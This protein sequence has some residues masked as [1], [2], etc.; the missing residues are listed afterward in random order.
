MTRVNGNGNG[1][2]PEEIKARREAFNKI[3]EEGHT[4]ELTVQKKD[5]KNSGVSYDY[6]DRLNKDIEAG[7]FVDNN[8]DGKNNQFSNYDKRNLGNEFTDVFTEHGYST[9]F[10]KMKAGEKYEITFDDYVRLA[11]AAGYELVKEEKPAPAPVEK[12]MPEIKPVPFT[13]PETKIPELKI[14]P[15]EPQAEQNDTVTWDI[16][17]TEYPDGSK[18]RVGSYS[19]NGEETP[20]SEFVEA[21]EQTGKKVV[22]EPD[23][24][25]A[26]AS[27]DKGIP[28]VEEVAVSEVKEEAP[29][30]PAHRPFLTAPVKAA[31][32]TIP[33]V[34]ADLDKPIKKLDIAP[35][36]VTETETAPKAKEEAPAAAPAEVETA[37]EEAPATQETQ[38]AEEKLTAAIDSD[39]LLAGKTTEERLNALRNWGFEATKKERELKRTTV[40]ETKPRF[41]GL[42][43][44]EYERALTPEELA[45]NQ[46]ALQELAAEKD[47]YKK[48]EVYVKNVENDE[49]WNGLYASQDLRDKNGN[50]VAEYPQYDRVTVVDAQDNERRVARVNT[51]NPKTLETTTQYFSL[52]VQKV[53]DPTMGSGV[54]Y[55]VVPDTTN[56]LKDVQLKKYEYTHSR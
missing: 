3:K 10:G 5:P 14:K 46:Q 23:A 2:T 9:K 18:E 54:Y 47:K 53:G 38:T 36:Q 34:T 11:D 33:T 30:A 13:I 51:Y 12:K 21:P 16:T 37:K 20:V 27:N 8:K 48:Y 29:A 44:K 4:I 56:E 26:K 39:P 6:M 43:K 31:P 40:T 28:A 45:A 32:L 42:G 41:L 55:S 25:P 19:V 52:D 7:I 49:Y 15:V 35:V 50:V 22:T 17:T 1:L 24:V